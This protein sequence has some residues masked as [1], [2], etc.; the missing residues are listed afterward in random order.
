MLSLTMKM[1]PAMFLGLLVFVVLE[2]RS[3]ITTR[4]NNLTTSVTAHPPAEVTL[5]HST[6]LPI[7]FDKQNVT[8]ATTLSLS[9]RATDETRTASGKPFAHNVTGTEQTSSITTT[10]RSSQVNITEAS[11]TGMKAAEEKSTAIPTLPP[12]QTTMVP[13]NT[14][15]FQTI[16]PINITD[17]EKNLT[18]VT[19]KTSEWSVNTTAL[20][21][22]PKTPALTTTLTTVTN[23]SIIKTTLS[24]MLPEHST[25][26]TTS[27]IT[28]SSNQTIQDISNTEFNQSTNQSTKATTIPTTVFSNISTTT[29]EILSTIFSQT[30]NATQESLIPIF[31]KTL[32]TSKP[33]SSKKGID[34]KETPPCSSIGVVKKC[35][36]VIASLAVV[37]TIFII[38]TIILCT[39]LS[40]RKFKLRRQQQ[41]TEMMCISS[42][43]PESSNP[44][45]RYTR[46]RSPVHN[47]VLVIHNCGDSDDE[48]GDNLTLSSFLPD[49]DRY[50]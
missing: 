47:G 29:A 8:T 12:N 46:Q 37:A 13:T 50:V 4:E 45:H 21:V 1:Y 19:S 41:G 38:S 49:N 31:P 42:L 27:A 32:S 35:L 43:L 36:I 40:S 39:K 16:L 11:T 14:T 30:T 7:I 22:A 20:P 24:T 23:K 17:E 5:P 6:P 15:G 26:T 28:R 44:H 25:A 10:T 3:E 18:T 2:I 9:H 33:T 48:I 34:N